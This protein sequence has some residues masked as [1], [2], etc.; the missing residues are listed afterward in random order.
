MSLIKQ[1]GHQAKEAS[2]DLLSLSTLEKNN[3]LLQLADD[4][5]S[6][7]D[8]IMQENEKDMA[9]AKNHDISKIMLDRLLLTKEGIR[10]IVEGV[11]K[12]ADLEDPIGQVIK[13]YTD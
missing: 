11:K 5:L 13:G 10:A 9:Q 2:F 6:N 4:L 8:V 12:V 3:F 7:S 1:L